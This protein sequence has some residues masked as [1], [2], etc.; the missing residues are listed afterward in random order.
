MSMATWINYGYGFDEDDFKPTLNGV[1]ALLEMAPNTKDMF[2]AAGY[3]G[4]KS[5]DE[6]VEAGESGDLTYVAYNSLYTP[7]V[8]AF[9]ELEDIRLIWA[10]D[11]EGNRFVMLPNMV[12]WEMNE[13]EKALTQEK[14]D[15]LF[16]KY[17]TIYCEGW[18]E[19]NE[20]EFQSQAAENF[21]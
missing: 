21:G 5:L 9:A 10:D 13:T 4:F 17:L 2:A 3:D 19:G 1:N 16:K 20:S 18:T 15:M 14:L 12:P 8:E 7:F 6:V 11:I